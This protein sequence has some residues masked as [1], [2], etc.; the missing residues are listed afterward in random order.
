MEAKLITINAAST[1]FGKFS[2]AD[3]E[4]LDSRARKDSLKGTTL[5]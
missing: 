1:I 3:L 5:A 4:D 2:L